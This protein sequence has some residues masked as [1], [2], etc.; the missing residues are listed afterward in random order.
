MRIM[1]G[2][3]GTLSPSFLY[4]LHVQFLPLFPTLL[5]TADGKQQALY[6]ATFPG[7]AERHNLPLVQAV[8]HQEAGSQASDYSFNVCHAQYSINGKYNPL[9]AALQPSLLTYQPD[10]SPVITSTM[11]SDQRHRSYTARLEGIHLLT[12]EAVQHTATPPPLCY[13]GDLLKRPSTQLVFQRRF[14]RATN[15]PA[16]LRGALAI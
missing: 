12:S 7:G 8:G 6:K 14:I 13:P 15:A 4:R 11:Q 10:S 1:W 3:Q 9:P 5:S 2:W 16:Q